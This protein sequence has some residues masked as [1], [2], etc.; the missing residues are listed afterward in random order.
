MKNLP[1]D[2][3]ALRRDQIIDAAVA[4]IAEQGIQNLSLSEIEKKADMSRGQLTYYFPAKEEILLAVFDRVLQLM[5]QRMGTPA[6]TA[7]VPCD[8]Q[9]WLGLDS[10]SVPDHF[11]QA[12]CGSGIWLP[13]IHLPFA[14]RPPRRFPPPPGHPV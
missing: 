12:A 6:E 5:Y 14:D 9:N 13:A 1:I 7:Q 10:A 2:I 11:P 4:V 8:Q 3:P